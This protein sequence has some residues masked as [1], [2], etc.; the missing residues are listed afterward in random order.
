MYEELAEIAENEFGDLVTGWHLFCRRAAI[1]LKLRLEIRDGT[2]LDIWVNSS[3][4]RYAYHWEQ[5]AVRGKIHRHDN[6]PDHPEIKT[7]P[8]H[9]H[10]GSEDNVLPSHIPDNPRLALRKFLQFVRRQ[11]EK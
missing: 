6:A 4:D 11:L 2:Y 9:F 3:R 8:K 5:R 7:F 1:P 10:D